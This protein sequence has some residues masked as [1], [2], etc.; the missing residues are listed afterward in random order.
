MG[1]RWEAYS[2]ALLRLHAPG[3]RRVLVDG[4]R[5]WTPTGFIDTVIDEDVD[6]IVHVDED[7]FVQS[8]P[9][10]T[11]LIEILER[12]RTLV[13]AGIQ[14]GGSYYREHNPAALNLF[15]VIFRASALR[16]VWQDKQAWQG[17]RF[18]APFA[19]QVRAQRPELDDA[20][21]QWDEGEPYYWLYWALLEQGGR[22]LYLREELHRPLWSS[23]IHAPDG[24]M[25]AEHLWYVREWFGEQ[26]MPGHD[27]ANV[28]RY[29]RWLAGTRRNYG[30]Q[31]R[32]WWFLWLSWLRRA[33][34]RLLRWPPRPAL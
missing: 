20:R 18:R 16:K 6:Y 3:W 26:T 5:N 10:L 1:S 25:V 13:A 17:S 32:Y 27:C 4:Q 31:P 30:S 14:D 23:R 34:W 28:T 9:A 21:I 29:R 19:E 8:G 33:G 22:F 11:A 2:Q 24:K 7:C 12:D 15:F